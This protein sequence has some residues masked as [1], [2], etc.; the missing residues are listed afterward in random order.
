MLLLKD[1]APVRLNIEGRSYMVYDETCYDAD[2]K[3][4]RERCGA[5]VDVTDM[6]VVSVATCNCG[7]PSNHV[8]NGVEWGAA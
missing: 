6:P 7:K 3:E 1:N 8:S 4:L 2:G 5:F